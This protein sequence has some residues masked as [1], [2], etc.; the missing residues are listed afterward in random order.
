[1]LRLLSL[2]AAFLTSLTSHQA[3]P[4]TAPAPAHR[5]VATARPAAPARVVATRPHAVTRVVPPVQGADVSWPN[6]RRTEGIAGRHGYELPMPTK[7]ARYVVLGA[8]NGPAWTRNPCLARQ[9]RWAK[10]RHLPVAA[11]AVIHYPTPHELARN[12]GHGSLTTRLRHAGAA[13]AR[14]ALATLRRAHVPTPMVWVDVETVGGHPW[15]RSASANRAVLSGV[16]AQY[17]K[18]HVRTG[19]YSYKHAWNTV[20][21]GRKLPRVPTWVPSGGATRSAA[22]RKCRMAS[23]S[24]GRVVMTQWTTGSRDYNI[25]CPGVRAKG[26]FRKA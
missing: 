9:M 2:A 21:G 12:G 3:P 11:Y 6:C 5:V 13:Q 19:L 10:A 18:S 22:L 24:G 7:A 14:H 1:L 26:L 20:M 4:T 17:R 8:T 23:F 15:S 16:L 25:T